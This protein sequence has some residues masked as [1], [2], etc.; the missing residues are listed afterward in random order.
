MP[1]TAE[2]AAKIVEI[3]TQYLSVRKLREL[4]TRLDAEVGRH[5]TNDSLKVTLAML[6]QGI[7]SAPADYAAHT[8]DY[9]DISYQPPTVA[10]SAPGESAIPIEAMLPNKRV[11]LECI[12]HAIVLIHAALVVANFLAV[13][14]LLVFAPWYIAIPLTTFVGWLSTSRAVE[15]PL[16][17]I[18]NYVRRASGRTEIRAFI[19]YYV[20]KPVYRY[21]QQL[22]RRG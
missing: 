2:E 6:K 14:W 10:L 19:G 12:F 3:S 5:T 16:T 15:C 18:E 11:W 22:R 1:T 9:A 8:M 13:F 21:L 17:R 4:F 7:T 20:V